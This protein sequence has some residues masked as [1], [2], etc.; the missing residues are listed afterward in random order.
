MNSGWTLETIT[1]VR[2]KADCRGWFMN[3]AVDL[4]HTEE[5]LDNLA[6]ACALRFRTRTYLV[7]APGER[8]KALPPTLFFY[9]R[10][11]T[12]A[13]TSLDSS[14][15]WP[16]GFWSRDPNDE[17]EPVDP[18]DVQSAGIRRQRI[19]FRGISPDGEFVW[20]Q[21]LE[22]WTFCVKVRVEVEYYRFTPD[23]CL[24]LHEMQRWATPED[25]ANSRFELIEDDEVMD[26]D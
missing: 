14:L 21:Q 24:V 6:I 1:S 5:D 26:C 7:A 16:M 4:C 9:E 19:T 11:H 2:E 3:Y 23:E 22:H 18:T 12:E 13:R 20:V 15:D 10:V 17:M 25:R 8:H